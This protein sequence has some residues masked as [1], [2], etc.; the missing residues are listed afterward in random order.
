MKHTFSIADFEEISDE[1]RSRFA[2]ALRSGKY[3]RSLGV[4]YNSDIDGYCC[5]GV[6][7]RVFEEVDT[8]DIDKISMPTAFFIDE[9]VKTISFQRLRISA[10]NELTKGR[11][12][13]C[14]LDGLND[15]NQLDFSDIAD[16]IEHG[17][18][19]VDLLNPMFG[20]KDDPDFQEAWSFN[21]VGAAS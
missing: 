16:L 1:D 17:Y 3:K 19:E 14:Y 10:A 7:A 4:M 5:L 6:A 15:S 20:E 12:V 13:V 8:R 21:I 9:K 18:L 11:E 2:E